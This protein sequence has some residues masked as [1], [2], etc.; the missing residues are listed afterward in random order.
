M[1]VMARPLLLALALFL[2]PVASAQQNAF[3]LAGPDLAVTVTRDGV[4]LP[5]TAVP[6]LRT[7]D[8]LTARAVL[9]PD[10]AARYR[11]VVAF[12]RGATNPP[13]KKW[14]FAVETWSRKRNVLDVTVPEGAEQ[15]IL[16]LAP[17]TGGGFD[18]VRGAVRGRP[19]V[20]VRA[21]QDLYQASLDRARL[22]AFVAAIGRIGDTA[23]ERL[24]TAAPILANAL[25]I[26]LNAECLT[27]Q[28]GLQAACLTQSRDALV[29]QAQRGTTL[30]ETLTGTPVDLAYRVAATPEGG[31]G[32][33]SPY[34]GLARDVARLFG[35]FR[36]AQYQYLPALSLGQGDR[37]RLQLNAAPSFQNPRSVLVAPL[38]PIGVAPPPIWR[39]AAPA[40]ICLTQPDM[41]L[42]LDDASLLFATGHARDLMLKITTTDGRGAELPLVADAERG[43][44]RLAN[45]SDLSG[46]GTVTDAVLQ[47]KWGF[48]PFSGPHLP[49]R[50]DVAGA[51]RAR[52]DDAVVVGRD[53]PLRLTGGASACIERLSLRDGDE[54]NRPL[55]WKAIGPEEAE[56][57]L[58]LTGIRPGPLQLT[59]A[60]YGTAR[61]DTLALTGRAEPSRL[62]RF[63]IHAGDRTGTLSGAR[64]DQ[65]AAL[66]L[67]DRSFVAGALTRGADGDRLELTTTQPIPAGSGGQAAVTL[68]DGRTAGV[69][70]TIG[71]PRPAARLLSR[72]VTATPPAG[73]LPIDLPDGLVPAGG[74]LTFSFA[75]TGTL[76]D[77][78]AIEVATADGGATS[79]LTF[80]SG[81][82]QRVGNDVI[83]ARIAPRQSLGASATGLL[84][85]RLRHGDAV[86]D[87]QRLAH[88]VRLPLLTALDCPAEGTDCR[89]LGNDLFLIA[90][91]GDTPDA[92][93]SIAVP[94]GFVGPSITLPRPG[95]DAVFIR[96][97]DAPDVALRVTVGAARA[98]HAA[99]GP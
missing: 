43:G 93:R 66:V 8:R 88:V 71:E 49:V 59:I 38:P 46:I 32:Y 16:F 27:R 4:E 31:A 10:Q 20:F 17:E 45:G 44:L 79:T 96:L 3:D 37:V 25:R 99:D 5:V 81:A 21:T 9:P 56:A 15:A 77:R 82:L 64:L 11:L 60:R 23:P 53:H 35:A 92:A 94:P 39:S 29:L 2:A 85:F 68:R 80:A 13:P 42:P 19:G 1:P 28:R 83:V 67:N 26:K 40:P 12:L 50:H 24:V 58:P 74:T 65:V 73:T 36:T 57:T 54:R 75:V 14:F 76:T 33:Y 86:G 98:S 30:A 70:A 52:P 78:D 51:W 47:G 90:A 34:I 22:D 18:A 87:W 48:D 84:R 91:V 6:A 97:H 7:G 63:V 61:P 62:D 95:G 55:Q 89:L 69:P 41:V 72:V